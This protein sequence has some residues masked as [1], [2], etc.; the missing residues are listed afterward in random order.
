MMRKLRIPRDLA[1]M[2]PSG[3]LLTLE[4]FILVVEM[5]IP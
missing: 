4:A 2:W 1:N 5:S 3:M